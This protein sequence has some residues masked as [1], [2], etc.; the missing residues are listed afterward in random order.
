M[1]GVLACAALVTLMAIGCA[2][3]VVGE[4]TIAGS[5]RGRRVLAV[6]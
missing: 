6:R 5:P 2:P 3:M 4:A 1:R